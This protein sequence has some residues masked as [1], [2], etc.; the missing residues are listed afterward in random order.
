M[1]VLLLII[2]LLLLSVPSFASGLS[3]GSGI[4]LRGLSC[5]SVATSS[6]ASPQT[7]TCPAG[8]SIT[9]QVCTNATAATAAQPTI[10]F[11]TGSTTCTSSAGNV[12]ATAI[13]CH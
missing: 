11:V 7:A 13:C 4:T 5:L 9:G 1:K 6:G 3:S 8:Y 2:C 10:N 12:T